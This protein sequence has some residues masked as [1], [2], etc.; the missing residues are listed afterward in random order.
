MA[1]PTHGERV[2]TNVPTP[3]RQ[4]YPDPSRWICPGG[5]GRIWF[6]SPDA[7]R[8]R[9]A[10]L[11]WQERFCN[12]NVGGFLGVGNSQKS[13]CLA[14]T[15]MGVRKARVSWA[16]GLHSQQSAA[17]SSP[18]NQIA[19]NGVGKAG[20]RF[21]TIGGFTGR[22]RRFRHAGN[23]CRPGLCSECPAP[24]WRCVVLCGN[25]SPLRSPGPRW[26]AMSVP[27]DKVACG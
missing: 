21:A 2:G 19:R 13:V 18:H 8:Y 24:V 16:I 9:A 5:R 20:R 25:G 23:R 1:L 7:I 22:G 15:L 4:Q 17:S 12:I 26:L 11:A 10:R 14:E 27:P 3:C 6:I